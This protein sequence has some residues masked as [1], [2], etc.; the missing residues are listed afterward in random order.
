MHNA[1]PDIGDFLD[2]WAGERHAWGVRDC[3]VG[4]VSSWVEA[5]TG[6]DPASGFRGRYST[7]RGAARMITRAGGPVALYEGLA[8]AVRWSGRN[9]ARAGDVGLV[10]G[11]SQRTKSGRASLSKR[12]VVLTGAICTGDRWAV[13]TGDGMLVAGLA[14]VRAWGP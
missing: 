5:C 7:A 14:F 9:I 2:R 3:S 12:S 4:F 8:H 13:F 6:I 1:V 11:L 10:I